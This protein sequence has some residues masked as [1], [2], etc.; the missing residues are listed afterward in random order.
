LGRKKS[1]Q[2]CKKRFAGRCLICGGVFS[3][4]VLNAHRVIPGEAY[5]FETI[6]PAC[7]TCHAR[8]HAGEIAVSGPFLSTGGRGFLVLEGGGER[9]VLDS[10]PG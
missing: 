10:R 1:R 9:F 5:R 2:H 4:S 3:P 7:P 8:I 6:L